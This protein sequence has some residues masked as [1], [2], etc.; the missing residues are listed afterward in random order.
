ML[1]YG[2]L[3][4]SRRSEAPA[5]ANIP[6]DPTVTTQ[7]A[8]SFAFKFYL[9]SLFLKVLLWSVRGVRWCYPELRPAQ[10]S[11]ELCCF[12]FCFFKVV[13]DNE[14]KRG[15]MWSTSKHYNGWSPFDPCVP[16]QQYRFQDTNATSNH[17]HKSSTE[18]THFSTARISCGGLNGQCWAASCKSL[19]RWLPS[20]GNWGL[21]R[22]AVTT[23][24][25]PTTTKA[26]ARIVQAV[27]RLHI[28]PSGKSIL[29]TNQ[30]LLWR[31]ANWRKRTFFVHCQWFFVR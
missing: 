12:R 27:L 11:C 30:H 5:V 19:N 6:K 15:C 9:Q 10:H 1:V 4:G 20:K 2:T 25:C 7:S 22:S 29:Q 21:A 13:I 23:C 24:G 26:R 17:A 31:K 28:L 16:T 14:A 8:P 18:N 3:D